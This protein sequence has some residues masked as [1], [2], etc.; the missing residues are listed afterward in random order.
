MS[1]REAASPVQVDAIRSAMSGSGLNESDQAELVMNRSESPVD[2][3]GY[4]TRDIEGVER[5]SLRN[6]LV[7]ILCGCDWKPLWDYLDKG[8]ISN[9][10]TFVI[11]IIGV[12]GAQ[13]TKE[14]RDGAGSIGWLCIQA[15]GLF[16][17]SGG[18]TNWLAVK[19][20]FD[21]VPGLV[22]SGI[23][24]Q[25]FKEIRQTVMET[26]LDTFFDAEFLGDYV[27]DK[28]DEFEKSNYLQG[29]IKAVLEGPETDEI[30]TKHIGLLFTKPEGMMLMMAG[31]D[32][33][34]IKPM[35]LPFVTGMDEEIAPMLTEGFDMKSM[36][37]AKAMRGQVKELMVTK[38][39]MLTPPMVKELVEDMIRT[40]LGWLV[41][42][43]NLFGG[44]IGLVCQL[45]AYKAYGV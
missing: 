13:M 9:I 29:K 20:L 42:W 44:I 2:G 27:V 34:T 1:E 12:V 32:A 25:Q 24:T 15:I 16:G 17:F 39:E 19:M 22:G 11:M 14:T 21:K 30:V 5:V 23:I 35:I 40:H 37:D 8:A 36:V 43:G 3:G 6:A 10:I 28:A 7:D 26:V 45:A 38:M 41:V 18:V 33:T 31:F 4:D